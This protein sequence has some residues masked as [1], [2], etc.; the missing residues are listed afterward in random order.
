VSAAAAPTVD[1]E[2][3]RRAV[4]MGGYF[5]C[6]RKIRIATIKATNCI[7]REMIVNI[8]ILLLSGSSPPDC[9]YYHSTLS[10]PCH[11]TY[12]SPL[13]GINDENYV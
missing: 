9:K 2:S 7:T 13:A 11:Y 12:F 10:N 5:S 1:L 3:M 4:H 6:F 8:T